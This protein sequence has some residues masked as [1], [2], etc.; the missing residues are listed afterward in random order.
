LEK[1]RPL[2]LI[3]ADGNLPFRTA[4]RRV[5]RYRKFGL[6]ALVRKSR[7]D[8]GGR[9][10]VSPK[11]KA[12]IEALALES[13]PLPVRS[14][15]RQVRQFAEATGEPLPRYGTVYDLVRDVPVGLLTTSVVN[16]PSRVE[17]DIKMARVRMMSI[18]LDPIRREATM[19]LEEIRLKDEKSRREIMDKPGCSPCDRSAVDPTYFETYKQYQAKQRAV[20]DPTTLILVDEADRL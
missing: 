3:A 11:I 8:R 4:Q 17:N 10:V 20:S 14:I 13:P 6:I 2:Q 9:R 12:A 19:V 18:V 7:G 5:S 16:T 15:C 1:N